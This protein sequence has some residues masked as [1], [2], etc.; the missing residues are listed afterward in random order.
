MYVRLAFAVAAHLEPE[1]LIVDEVL[2]VG[3]AE[4][5]KKCLGKMEDVS[6]TQGRTVLFVSHQMNAI[7]SLCTRCLFLAKGRLQEDGLPANVIPTYLRT[8]TGVSEWRNDGG[9]HA[10]EYFIP[11][12]FALVDPNLQPLQRDVRGDEAVGVL[13][14]GEVAT[15]DAALV[16]G[17]AVYTTDATLLYWSVQTD[18]AHEHWPE[19]RLGTNRLVCWLPRHMLN[20]GEYRVELIVS[21]HCRVWFCQPGVN[22]P[23]V[24]FKLR[25]GLSESPH[26]MA[27]RPGLL[28]PVLPFETLSS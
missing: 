10:N 18:T 23:A 7:Q 24:H 17:F 8:G 15:A 21:L 26:W 3:D 22:A 5:Q 11:T 16:V 6:R 25:G 2:A 20:E 12:R 14:E 9:D 1:I 19:L 13:L 4:F 28:G 27:A